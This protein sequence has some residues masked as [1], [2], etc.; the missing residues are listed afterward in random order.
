VDGEVAAA[1]LER[2]R[3]AFA[4]R[5]VA[6]ELAAAGEVLVD[7]DPDAVEQVVANLLSNVEKYAAAGGWVRVA[8]VPG[9]AKVVVVVEDRGPGIPAARADDVFRPFV[10]LSSA[11]T[12][13]VARTGIGLT[14]A[15]DLARL[16]GGDLVL[17][18]SEV[19]ARFEL[20]L[21]SGG[22]GGRP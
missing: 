16:H 18:A 14:L 22:R 12:E 2:F 1:A 17:A 4:A 20:V 10:R 15:R 21:P 8:V 5:A 11:L 7:H 3:P 13:G 19:G 6:V 9:E